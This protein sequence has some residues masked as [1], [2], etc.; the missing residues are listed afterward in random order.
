MQ[1]F[2]SYKLTGSL[3]T[4]ENLLSTLKDMASGNSKGNLD[5]IDCEDAKALLYFD[6]VF[7]KINK[8]TGTL[9]LGMEESCNIYFVPFLFDDMVIAFVKNFPELELEGEGYYLDDPQTIY[10]SE[11]NSSKFEMSVRTEEVALDEEC[12]YNEE[13]NLYS[14]D[15][16]YCNSTINFNLDKTKKEPLLIDCNCCAASYEISTTATEEF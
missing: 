6:P 13:K 10:F 2:F 7:K 4:L 16:R 5:G 1:G 8:T 11:A 3:K 15:C 14:Y 12:F 9:T